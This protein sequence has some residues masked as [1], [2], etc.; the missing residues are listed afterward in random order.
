MRLLVSSIDLDEL[1]KDSIGLVHQFDWK[2]RFA[3]GF[4]PPS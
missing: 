3:H 2:Q 4:R 1:L